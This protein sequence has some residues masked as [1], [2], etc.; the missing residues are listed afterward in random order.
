MLCS[1]EELVHLV[2]ISPEE[3]ALV[4]GDGMR[5]TKADGAG[6]GISQTSDL[7]ANLGVRD[8]T[9]EQAKTDTFFSDETGNTTLTVDQVTS[10]MGYPPDKFQVQIL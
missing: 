3:A 5:G 6:V 4:I 8:A 2:D 1:P 10:V 7:T 9:V